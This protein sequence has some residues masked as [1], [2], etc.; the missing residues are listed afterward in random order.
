MTP[1]FR[2]VEVYSEGRSA[3]PDACEDAYVI[4]DDFAAVIDGCTD[5]AGVPYFGMSSG[6][7]AAQVLAAGIERLPAD[8]AFPDAVVRLSSHLD[9]A[10]HRA[11]PLGTKLADRP[12]AGVVMYSAARREVWRLGDCHFALDAQMYCGDKAIDEVT[13]HARAAYLQVLL[14]GGQTFDALAGDDP[15]RALILPLLREQ[16]HL[17]NAEGSRYAYGSFDGLTVPSRFIEVFPVPAGT[18]NLILATDG[19]LVPAP[20]LQQAEDHLRQSL[21]HDP[22]RVGEFPST[23]GVRPGATSF[24]DRTYLRLDITPNQPAVSAS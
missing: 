14:A 19:Y 1:M 16:H 6:R 24:D 21:T 5:K 3:D 2:P 18:R 12:S 22:L 17:R 15:G 20:T 13:S 8:I 23:K 4:R 7:F 11:L 9:S 10:I